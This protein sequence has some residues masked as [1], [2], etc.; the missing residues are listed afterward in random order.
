MPG[1]MS[2]DNAGG[3]CEGMT[4]TRKKMKNLRS[5]FLQQ[6]PSLKSKYRRLDSESETSDSFDSLAIVKQ[7]TPT[8]TVDTRKN[9]ASLDDVTMFWKNAVHPMFRNRRGGMDEFKL[10]DDFTTV[11][12]M[13]YQSLLEDMNLM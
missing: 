4:K 3:E 13:M 5:R 6:L 9:E 12:T 2:G 11:H 1:Y 7:T 8:L 10:M